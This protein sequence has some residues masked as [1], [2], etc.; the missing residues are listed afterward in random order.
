MSINC[1][2]RCETSALG[3]ALERL[4]GFGN[5][6]LA[7]RDSVLGSEHAL[8]G[9]W[10][11][12]RA[13]QRAAV[14]QRRSR[15]AALR[16]HRHSGRHPAGYRSVAQS[17]CFSSRPSIPAPAQCNGGDSPQNCQFGNLGRNALRGPDFVWS[18]FYLTKWF[19]LTEHV[20]LRFE[21]PVLQCLQPSE[22]W[23]CRAWC[24]QAFPANL[25][26]R[27]DLARSLTRPLRRPDCS[28]LGWAAIA[29][30]A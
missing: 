6:V 10:K 26:R 8:F 13:W 7:Q 1:P 25:R 5:R 21:A 27:Q 15:R 12:H 2:S 30:H 11:R 29:V 24:W 9:Q 3:Y 14:R 16:T 4:A 20:K 17:R 23:R 22:L 19:P 28:A 18:D